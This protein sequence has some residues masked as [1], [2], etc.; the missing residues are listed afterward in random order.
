MVVVTLLF[1]FYLSWRLSVVA[2][3]SVPAIVVVS[4][5]Y[6]SYIRKLSK[7]TQVG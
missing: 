3:I 1:M 5:Y 7:L 6:G 4:K 2:F